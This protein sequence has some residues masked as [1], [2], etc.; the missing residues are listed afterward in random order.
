MNNTTTQNTAP[1]SE[2]WDDIT[3]TVLSSSGPIEVNKYYSKSYRIASVYRCLDDPASLS[4]G[5]LMAYLMATLD[6]TYVFDND[7]AVRLSPT[8]GGLFEN[9]D[10]EIERNRDWM[11]STIADLGT[12]ILWDRVKEA[13][14]SLDAHGMSRMMNVKRKVELSCERPSLMS[15]LDGDQ[16]TK[17]CDDSLFLLKE[18]NDPKFVEIRDRVHA[19]TEQDDVVEGIREIW[20]RV[21]VLSKFVLKT[22]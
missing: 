7:R 4:G 9:Q 13:P 1:S 21:G 22:D 3:P 10:W 11:L 17:L 6:M 12:T 20:A 14:I 8:I 18:V 19:V 2:R 5:E 15:S 16:M